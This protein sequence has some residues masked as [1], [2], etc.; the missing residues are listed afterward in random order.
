MHHPNKC[1]LALSRT[2]NK[3]QNNTQERLQLRLTPTQIY[4]KQKKRN[5]DFNFENAHLWY[6]NLDKLIH[7][8]NQDGRLHVFYSTPIEV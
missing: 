5:S 7:Y 2:T 1:A 8:A 4:T 6:K 3:T